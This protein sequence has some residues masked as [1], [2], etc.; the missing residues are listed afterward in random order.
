M[1]HLQGHQLAHVLLGLFLNSHVNGGK[2]RKLHWSER[3]AALVVVKTHVTRILFSRVSLKTR[4]FIMFHY[5]VQS[6]FF[7]M[8]IG[9]N[10]A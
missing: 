6:P 3:I 5:S 8:R 10:S 7:K 9:L 2:C 4:K 1:F